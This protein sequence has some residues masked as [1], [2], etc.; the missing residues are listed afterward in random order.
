MANNFDLILWTDKLDYAPGDT[1][2]FT[3]EGATVG[4]TIEFQVL[5]VT[6]PGADGVY[7]TLDD[8]LDAGPDGVTGTADDGYGTTGA[9]HE[10]FYVTDGVYE[11]DAGADGIVG[12]ADDVI[13]GDQDMTA[14]GIIVTDWYVNP[15]DS[16]DETFLLTAEEVEAG[17]DGEFGTADDVYTGGVGTTSFTDG[18]QGLGAWR[19]QPGPTLDSWDEGTTIQQANS[20]YAE[21][22]VIPFRW[23]IETGNPAP[24]L[25][26]GVFYTIQLDYAFAGGT[27]SPDKF[28]FDYLTSYNATEAADAPFGPG[29][30]LAGFQTGNLSTVAIPVDPNPDIVGQTAGVFDLFNIDSTTVVFGSYTADPVNANQED[31]Q[32]TITFT[33]DDGDGNAGEFVNVGVAWG[34][35]LASQIDYGFENGAASFPGASP[36]MVVDLDPTTSGDQT[37]LNINPNAIVAQGQITIIK[38]ALPD[39]LQ[40]FGFTITGPDGTTIYPSDAQSTSPDNYDD[41]NGSFTLDDDGDPTDSYPTQLPQEITFFGLTEGVYTITEDV[42]SG[43]TLSNITGTE[44]GAEDTTPDD[45]FA[46]DTVIVKDV[47]ANGDGTFADAETVLEGDQVVDYRFTITAD[48]NNASTD[49]LTISSISDPTLNAAGVTDA[50]LLAAAVAANGGVSPIVLNAGESLTFTITDVA[51]TLDDGTA[52][53][54]PYVNTVTV[55]AA[56]DEGTVA[57]DD[58]G[59]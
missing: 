30:D 44:T 10:P 22:E 47:D 23:T 58:R 18:A 59:G 17:A 49:P 8:T 34:A 40:D 6:D 50:Q 1:A 42:V 25:Q 31:R 11:I 43:W 2:T 27:T 45:I 57:T 53:Q 36:Q 28:F 46:G 35:H 9:G 29:S 24:Q 19:N 15:D 20:V 55:T 56:D 14:N 12:T 5:H 37:N 48:A 39:D 33:P 41:T 38:D 54:D 21:D 4:G 7:G 32:L 52:G 26:E 3:V 16:L 13:I 51:V